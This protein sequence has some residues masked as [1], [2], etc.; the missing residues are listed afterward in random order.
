MTGLQAHRRLLILQQHLL[1]RQHLE[2]ARDAALVALVRHVEGVLR[3]VHG[4]ALHHGLALD[5]T[6]RGELVLDILEG[7]NDGVF[8]RVCLGLVGMPRL[9]GQRVAL[10]GIKQQLCR[11]PSQT[12]QRARPLQPRSAMRA[13]KAA[14][15]AQSD[16]GVVRADGNADLRIR[17]R[18]PALG[19]GDVRPALEQLRRHA[20]WHIGGA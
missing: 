4:K 11:L 19:G 12:P 2:I 20:Q 3:G 1:G 7:K 17:G 16:V 15:P 13:L 10:A 8:V 5:H 6:Q 18:S 14:R 9:I